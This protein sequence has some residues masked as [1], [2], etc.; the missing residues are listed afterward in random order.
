MPLIAVYSSFAL[1]DCSPWKPQWL[2][3]RAFFLGYRTLRVAGRGWCY[4]HSAPS[5][6][7]QSWPPCPPTQPSK[8]PGTKPVKPA[9]P[10]A[11]S[12][13]GATQFAGTNS[14]TPPPTTTPGTNPSNTKC[15][16]TR[17]CRGPL[18]IAVVEVR[19]SSRT[20]T[21]THNPRPIPGHPHSTRKSRK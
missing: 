3:A 20:S 10:P 9:K 11:P 17:H 7:R 2:P 6:Q 18:K 21:S 5:Q 13:A 15:P 1:S 14:T 12:P 4:T 19:S 16:I 8:T